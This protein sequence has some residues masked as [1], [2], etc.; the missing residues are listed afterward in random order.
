MNKGGTSTFESDF[1]P[2]KHEFSHDIS[3]YKYI[4]LLEFDGETYQQTFSN[5]E[6][7][8]ES[9]EHPINSSGNHGFN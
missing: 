2:E 3:L 4:P 7:F 8:M 6:E 9:H 5:S 1:L